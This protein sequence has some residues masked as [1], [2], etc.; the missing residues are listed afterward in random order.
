MRII[1]F[2]TLILA[3]ACY[4]GNAPMPAK[5]SLLPQMLHPAYRDWVRRP[6]EMLSFWAWPGPDTMK[7]QVTRTGVNATSLH[8]PMW[9]T[10]DAASPLGVHTVPAKDQLAVFKVSSLEVDAGAGIGEHNNAWFVRYPDWFWQLRPQA[11][12]QDK[13]GKVIRAGENPVPALNDQVLSDLSRQQ[14]GDMARELKGNKHIRYWVLGGEESYPDYFGLPQGDYRPDAIKQFRTWQARLGKKGEAGADQDDWYAFRE[15]TLTDYYAGDTAFLR[16]CDP[17]RPVMIPT[18]GNPFALDLRARMG[19]P[20]SDL[21]GVGD[22]FEAG[23]ISIDDDPERLIRL[24]LDMQTSFGVPVAAPRLG[25]KQLDPKAQ[26]GGRSF[27]PESLRRTVYEALGM[28]VWHLGL[29]QW[30]G[31]LPDGE[32]GISG[33]P[34]EAECRK[35]FGEIEKAGPHLTGCSR[36]VPQVAIYISDATWRRR[37][38]DRWTLLYDQAIKRGWHVMLITDAE[39]GP[40]LACNTP[41]IVSVD[42]PIITQQTRARLTEYMRAGGTVISVGALGADDGHGHKAMSVPGVVHIA[43][44]APGDPVKLVHQTQTPHGASTW[45]AEVKPLPME[46][47]EAAVSQKADIR[48]IGPMGPIECLPL[49]DGTNVVAV[50]INRSDKAQDIRLDPSPRIRQHLG[51]WTACD[52]VS[53]KT[54]NEVH[55]AP[56][57]TALIGILSM[58]SSG[59]KAYAL[60]RTAD[61]HLYI[62]PA[63]RYDGDMLH[64]EAQVR[65]PKDKSALGAQVRVRLVPGPFEWHTLTET[66]PGVFSLQIPRDRLPRFYNPST[67]QYEPAAGATEL[68]FDASLGGL[69]GGTCTTVRW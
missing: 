16:S 30:A 13:D 49:T 18:H 26:G 14:M 54:G 6:G 68:I 56:H 5:D 39:V 11:S 57:G 42:N 3:T 55:L 4:G 61:H 69:S 24:T 12:M 35:V 43:D 36:L 31:S 63:A 60:A 51:M 65:T 7:D 58:A 28:G 25:N 15:S 67:G 29:V 66:R 34:A 37:W 52:L 44:D 21:A 32:W 38:Q 27:S 59:P 1:P 53:G 33:T 8:M 48:P 2:I 45:R 46:V 17:T 10:Q 64:I 50:L 23:P 47:L 22:G 20:V 41:V 40:D 9:V 62:R 19:Y